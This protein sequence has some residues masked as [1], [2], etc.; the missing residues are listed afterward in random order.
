MDLTTYIDLS[1]SDE[2]WFWNGIDCASPFNFSD[3][4]FEHTN[5]ADNS[6]TSMISSAGE[7]GIS[8][9]FSLTCH[10][11]AHP[12]NDCIKCLLLNARS[13]RYKIHDLQT[14][15]VMDDFDIIALTETWLELQLDGYNIF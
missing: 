11:N 13:I 15:L 14:L 4:F 5:S 10:I 8:S 2:Q 9:A 7:N 6:R 1:S 12:P 3:S